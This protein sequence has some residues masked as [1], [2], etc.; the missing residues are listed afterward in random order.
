MQVA[1]GPTPYEQLE[2]LPETLVGECLNGM[3]YTQPR[4]RSHH[5]LASVRLSRML[6]SV[7]DSDDAPD[8]DGWWLLAEPE[9]H[10]VYRV[11]VV[12]PDLAGWRRQRMPQ[13]PDVPM[14]E[15]V[16][17]WVCEILSPS[18]ARK[19]REIKMPLYARDGVGWLWL[20]DPARRQIEVFERDGETWQARARAGADEQT[21]LAPFPV[22]TL[23]LSH[24]WA[25]NRS[26]R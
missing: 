13:F 19:D 22:V 15:I 21:A 3:L 12:V 2:A 1:R 26:D 14:F 17:D 25:P 11:E 23:T 10:F 8:G 18:T 16:P 20:I 6:G 24:L 4:P 7:Y 5:A 9:I